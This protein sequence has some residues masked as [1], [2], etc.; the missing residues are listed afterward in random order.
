LRGVRNPVKL[1]FVHGCRALYAN[2]RFRTAGDRLTADAGMLLSWRIMLQYINQLLGVQI[3]LRDFIS[4][5]AVLVSVIAFVSKLT[6]D[7]RIAR[8]RE[9]VSYIEK[10]KRKP[11]SAGRTTARVWAQWRSART[12]FGSILG[13]WSWCRS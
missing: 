2:G 8:Y 9:T 3:E 11:V 10:R 6:S 13:R 4:F 5:A 7:T 1:V 12:R